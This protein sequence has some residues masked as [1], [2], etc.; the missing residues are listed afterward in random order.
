RS[1][2][3]PELEPEVLRHA[4][5]VDDAYAVVFGKGGEEVADEAAAFDRGIIDGA[6]NGV[7]TVV[8]GTGGRLRQLQTGYV[9]NYALAIFVGAALIV[10]YYVV[11][12]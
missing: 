11:H 8:R 1:A 9:R 6:V 12:P 4:W 10:L 7:A 3:Q 2:N 5:Y